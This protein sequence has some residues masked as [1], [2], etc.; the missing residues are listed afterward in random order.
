MDE[1]LLMNE[2]EQERAEEAQKQADNAVHKKI[3]AD[4]MAKWKERCQMFCA[5][6]F[7]ISC[8]GDKL[9]LY[10]YVVYC[11]FG[12]FFFFFL[13]EAAGAVKLGSN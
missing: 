10:Q 7:P 13:T 6:G 11:G 1:Q 8:A 12:F 5:A 3:Y 2:R 4:A 9:L